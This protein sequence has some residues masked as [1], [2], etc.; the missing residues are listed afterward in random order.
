MGDLD[1]EIC[2]EIWTPMNRLVAD[3]LS[4]AYLDRHS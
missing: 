4:P 3:V 1:G 2:G